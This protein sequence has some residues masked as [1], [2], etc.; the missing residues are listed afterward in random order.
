MEF[1]KYIF[2]LGAGQA[3]LLSVFLLNKQENKVANRFLIFG[4]II[5]ALDLLGLIFYLDRIFYDYPHLIGINLAFPFVYGPEVY[6]YTKA[7]RQNAD[8]I[9]FKN[10]LHFIPFAAVLIYHNFA[11]ENL[12]D[13]FLIGIA[14][15]KFL[16]P[17]TYRIIG[18]L[19]PVHGVIYVV[20]TFI[21]LKEINL[22]L[23]TAY[24]RIEDAEIRWMH[25]IVYGSAMVWIMVII[26][27]SLDLMTA[28]KFYGEAIIYISLSVFIFVLSINS[29][30]QPQRQI[31]GDEPEIVSGSYKKSGLS[32]EFAKEQLDKL[33]QCLEDEKL[34][35]Q[36]NLSLRDLADKLEISTHNLSEIINSGLNKN[37]YDLIN[38]YRI[39]EVK[40]LI[41]NDKEARYS[42]IA[43]AFDAGFSSK[44]TFNTL[45]KKFCK[46]TPSE[47][48]NSIA[49]TE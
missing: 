15:G 36:N 4:N 30:K 32:P 34:Y 37:F 20:L 16:P 24:S 42:I 18:I 26:A 19:I 11:A 1:L 41:E 3:I 31:K 46:M 21:N 8:K 17:L 25:I 7:I 33:L 48:R 13:D 10:L 44:T 38:G 43:L 28:G 14:L 35:T 27:Y 39:E 45:F 23:K 29:Y 6:L 2:V 40:R 9:T 12:S 22:K 49:L 5:F 47:Y